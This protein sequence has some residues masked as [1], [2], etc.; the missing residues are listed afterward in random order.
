M[1][2]YLRWL[3]AA[4]L[5]VLTTVSSCKKETSSDTTDEGTTELTTHTDDQ[6]RISIETDAVV[7]D[8]SVAMESTTGF[9]GFSLNTAPPICDATIS[10]DTTGSTKRMTITYTGSN[11][12]GGH[13]RTGSIIL[14]MAKGV[15]WKDAGAVVTIT[16]QQ[17]KITRM[18]DQKSFTLNGTHTITNES[19]GLLLNLATLHTI[20]H[21]ISSSDMSITFDNNTQRTWQL[22]KKRVF[23]YNNGLVI[24]V[25]GNH[26]GSG[27]GGIAVWGTNRFGRAFTTTIT[28][29]LLI[30]QDC[31][32]R[33][34]SGTVTHEGG[35]TATVTFGLDT[36]GNAATCPG[37]GTYYYK[38]DWTSPAGKTYSKVQPY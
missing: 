7:N 37:S 12:S 24:T 16:F 13:T 29:P 32:F 34:T 33:I 9:S 21:T 10:Y 5:A 1:K 30:K 4:V 22:A 35:A 23:T 8:A 20:T 26:S 15:H 17:L 36:D 28:E 25:T 27:D 19:G 11:C 6:S 3:P 2:M 38:L 31:D 18:R 14:T